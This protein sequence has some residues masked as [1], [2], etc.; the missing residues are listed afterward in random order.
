MKKEAC[1]L[2][3]GSFALILCLVLLAQGCGK[4]STSPNSPA[5]S[6]ADKI[7]DEY[8]NLVNRYEPMLKKAKAAN[9]LM[10]FSSL[11]DRLTP[12][13]QSVIDQMNQVIAQIHPNEFKKQQSRFNRIN[14]K[15]MSLCRV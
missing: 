12:Q 9:N 4:V 11:V 6:Q 7:L 5:L 2:K 10:E 15:Y 1:F 8:E 3:L 13:V 14:Q